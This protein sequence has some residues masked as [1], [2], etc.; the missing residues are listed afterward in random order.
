M[1]ITIVEDLTEAKKNMA[2]FYTPDGVR[3]LSG[4]LTDTQLDI[5]KKIIAEFLDFI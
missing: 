3:S 5:I 2:T 4:C 1:N